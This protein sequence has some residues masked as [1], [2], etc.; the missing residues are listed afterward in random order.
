MITFICSLEMK[1]K[2]I[3]LGY[4]IYDV[5]RFQKEYKT[6]FKNVQTYLLTR[7][8]TTITTHARNKPPITKPRTKPTK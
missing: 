8:T 5:E 3:I 4:Q 2:I 1:L 6:P 7:T